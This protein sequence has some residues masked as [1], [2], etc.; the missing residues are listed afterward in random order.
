MAIRSSGAGEQ[1]VY[2]EQPVVFAELDLV[3][4][5]GDGQLGLLLAVP[6]LYDEVLLVEVEPGPEFLEV[7][8][9]E[10]HLV[11]L[12]GLYPVGYDY[13]ALVPLVFDLGLLEQL[14]AHHELVGVEVLALLEVD[15]VVEQQQLLGYYFCEEQVEVVL[16]VVLD[17]YLELELAVA[18]AFQI[19]IG[20]DDHPLVVLVEH[21]HFGDLGES[22]GAAPVLELQLCVL[23]AA[24]GRHP[25]PVVVDQALHLELVHPVRLGVVLLL[26]E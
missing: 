18:L 15:V 9:G 16:H 13:P 24:D 26:L 22:E 2:P 19:I 8:H 20:E 11:V 4:D 23:D 3:V 5:E 6:D 12:E 14:P 17:K 25:L 1:A 21:L 10:G 7:G